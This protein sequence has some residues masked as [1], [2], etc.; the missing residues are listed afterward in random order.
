M[1][2]SVLGGGIVRSSV[3]ESVSVSGV[4]GFS[5]NVRRSVSGDGSVRRSV[6]WSGSVSG[7]GSNSSSVRGMSSLARQRE[8]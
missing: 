3:D 4:G 5:G 2:K 8:W 7:R 1:S 6:G